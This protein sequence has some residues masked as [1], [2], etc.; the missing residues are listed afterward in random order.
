MKRCSKCGV[1]K[2]LAE[3]SPRPDSPDGYRRQCRECREGAK[4]DWYQRNQETVAQK[5]REWREQNADWYKKRQRRNTL[6]RLYNLTPEQYHDMLDAQDGKCAICQAPPN[7]ERLAVDH[8]HATGKVRGLL[9]RR[10]NQVLGQ[11]E[12]RPQWLRAAADY[13][14]E[15]DDAVGG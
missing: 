3:F 11:F 5:Q 8:D 15:A 6:R 2:P 9:C 10:C 4:A 7:G 12:D 14:E 13:L 1:E